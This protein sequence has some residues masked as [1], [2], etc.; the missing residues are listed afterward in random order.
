MRP[1]L[2]ALLLASA[3]AANAADGGSAI[4]AAVDEGIKARSAASAA[5]VSRDE[6]QDDETRLIY[7]AALRDARSRMKA[8]YDRAIA[9][10]Q[11]AYGLSAPPTANPRVVPPSLPD[12]AWAAGLPAPR[13]TAFTLPIYR[14][15]KGADDS[16]HFISDDP[17]GI[18]HD[19]ALAMT[20]PDGRTALFSETMELAA[21]N[22][23][24]GI[25]ALTIHHENHHYRELITTG[26]DTHEQM[27]IRAFSAS[28][29]AVDTFIPASNPEL[30]EA[31]KESI[32][33]VIAA[34][35]AALRAGD[36]HSPF[37]SKEQE[38]FNREAFEKQEAEE[39]EYAALVQQVDRLRRE[40]RERQ[41]SAERELRW[42]KF[43]VWTLYA[44]SYVNG[45]HEGDPEWGRPDM[46][47]EREEAY[48]KYLRSG[49]VVMTKGEIDAGLR[50]NDLYHSGDL[51]R[52][53]SRMVEMIR[54]LPGPADEDWL[55]DRIEY[56]RRGGRAGE[57]IGG[58]LEYIRR[59]VADGTAAIVQSASAPFTG[60]RTTGSDS[61]GPDHGSRM[62]DIDKLP[63]RQLRGISSRGW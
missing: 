1:F 15:I 10:T 50:R 17:K 34:N 58:L 7:W 5:M 51:G 25:L 63:W 35:D 4:L 46:I 3:A 11:E 37:P 14:A 23:E 32:S 20:D 30:R 31:I 53:H 24:P 62:P 38:R 22:R 16:L 44:C 40:R 18:G 6:S 33:G 52:C 47:R 57:I 49:L 13:S 29:D 45:V 55:M 59:S 2:A 60:D 27:E 26:W 41:A 8:A 39:R 12:G 61:R 9:L 42:Q 43:K 28:L 19:D 56:E 48:R 21:A 36:I 54:D